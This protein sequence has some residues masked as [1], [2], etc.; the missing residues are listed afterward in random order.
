MFGF[1]SFFFKQNISPMASLLSCLVTIIIY[2]GY[3]IIF[4][5]NYE[6]YCN[7]P[8]Q[9]F[10]L[11]I[12]IITFLLQKQFLLHSQSLF[13]FGTYSTGNYYFLNIKIQLVIIESLKHKYEMKINFH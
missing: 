11:S 4:N 13:I 3:K 12:K 6:Y 7:F 2:F 9:F 10:F 8:L 5:F 1:L